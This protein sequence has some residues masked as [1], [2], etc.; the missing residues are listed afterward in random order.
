MDWSRIVVFSILLSAAASDV[1]SQTDAST[2]AQININGVGAEDEAWVRG[3]IRARENAPYPDSLQSE[4]LGA[5][6]GS[7]RFLSVRMRRVDVST[8]VLRLDID[9]SPGPPSPPAPP[10]V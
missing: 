9:L 5:L 6:L 10:P 1:F 3:K 8:G 4:D 2:L 7:G